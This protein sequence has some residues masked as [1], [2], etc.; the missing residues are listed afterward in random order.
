MMFYNT[1]HYGDCLLSLY[2][3]IKTSIA[4]NNMHFEFYCNPEYHHQLQEFIPTTSNVKLLTD[5]PENAYNLWGYATIQKM[6]KTVPPQYPIHSLAYPDLIDVGGVVC[7]T[8]KFICNELSLNCSFRN[9][10]DVIFDLDIFNQN[11]NT[12][13]YDFLFINSYCQSGQ[14]HHVTSTEQDNIFIELFNI[15]NKHN[16]SYITTKKINEHPCTLDNNMSL[17]QIG[18][19]A[20]NCKYIIG[21]PTSP[22]FC[23]INK[24]SFNNCK[25]F[26]NFTQDMCTFDYGSKFKTVR[27]LPEIISLLVDNNIIPK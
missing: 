12:N 6:Q 3:L 10:F 17:V 26:I 22:F 18:Q 2:F 14:M 11:T 21:V 4:N 27:S 13:T 23:C 9:K 16:L 15:A 7:N 20:K 25:L 24:F 5:L 8:N 19:L 1:Y